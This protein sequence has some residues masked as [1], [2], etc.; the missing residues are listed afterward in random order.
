M[1]EMELGRLISEYRKRRGWSQLNLALE[2]DTTQTSVSGI[3]S[4]R[5]KNPSGEIVGRMCDALELSEDERTQV[6]R[7][8]IKGTP[9]R[10]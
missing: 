1:C 9:A 2:A 5:V 8:V 4:G 10:G 7:T 6:A 3:E